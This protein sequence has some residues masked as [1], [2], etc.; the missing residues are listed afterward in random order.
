MPTTGHR[1][2]WREEQ[3]LQEDTTTTTIDTDKPEE[4]HDA[5]A[6]TFLAAL[7]G[8]RVEQ[9]ATGTVATAKKSRTPNSRLLPTAAYAYCNAHPTYS[10]LTGLPAGADDTAQVALLFGDQVAQHQAMDE[11]S[12]GRTVTNLIRTLSPKLESESYQQT[13]VW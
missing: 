2:K 10:V 3:A 9:P 12:R 1:L 7:R 5:G 11:E 6:G 13:L 4:Q 8:G